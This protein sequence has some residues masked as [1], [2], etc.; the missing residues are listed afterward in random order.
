M[1]EKYDFDGS[2]TLDKDELVHVFNDILAR[3]GIGIVL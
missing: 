1:F 3:F 2:G